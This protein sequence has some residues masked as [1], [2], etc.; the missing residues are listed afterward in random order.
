MFPPTGARIQAG[1]IEVEEINMHVLP[2]MC[3]QSHSALSKSLKSDSEGFEEFL[4]LLSLCHLHL[5]EYPVRRIRVWTQLLICRL[6]EREPLRVFV[7][8]L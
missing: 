6:P 7:G 2:N 1:L 8:S 3:E 5:S 4:R